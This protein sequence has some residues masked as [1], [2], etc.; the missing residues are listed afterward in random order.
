MIRAFDTGE[1]WHSPT[2]RL[3]RCSSGTRSAWAASAADVQVDERTFRAW[4]RARRRAGQ[5][6]TD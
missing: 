1:W 5:R 6:R 4:D 3:I 2:D